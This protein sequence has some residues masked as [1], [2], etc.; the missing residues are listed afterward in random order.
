MIKHGLLNCFVCVFSGRRLIVDITDATVWARKDETRER[1]KEK[2]VYPWQKS[3]QLCVAIWSHFWGLC[4]DCTIVGLN[5]P[6]LNVSKSLNYRLVNFFFP[7]VT[8]SC[9]ELPLSE[10]IGLSM[11]YHVFSKSTHITPSWRQYVMKYYS[12]VLSI[13]FKF[14]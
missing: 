10:V 9:P 5:T 14:L 13:L 4:G 8:Y 2:V 7:K 3:R 1:N 6:K 11:F 12:D